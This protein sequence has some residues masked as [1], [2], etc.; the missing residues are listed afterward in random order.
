MK[1]SRKYKKRRT[2]K[3]KGSGFRALAN[4]NR[5]SKDWCFATDNP[6]KEIRAYIEEYLQK[7]NFGENSYYNNTN[8][9]ASSFLSSL[10]K[11]NEPFKKLKEDIETRIKN[12]HQFRAYFNTCLGHKKPNYELN[13]TDDKFKTILNEVSNYRLW[14]KF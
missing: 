3:Q 4:L 9:D 8:M 14:N 13:L 10:E 7:I 12:S 5:T 1:F 2:K 11:G 6:E